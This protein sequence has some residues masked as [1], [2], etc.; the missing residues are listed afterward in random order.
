M[1]SMLRFRNTIGKFCKAHPG[2]Q[3]TQDRWIKT[4]IVHNMKSSST[5]ESGSAFDSS[6][7]ASLDSQATCVWD[8]SICLDPVFGPTLY[9]NVYKNSSILQLHEILDLIPTSKFHDPTSNPFELVISQA[10]HPF[11][12][13][14]YFFIHPCANFELI[15]PTL[16]YSSFILWISITQQVLG[17]TIITLKDFN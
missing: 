9:F 17:I 13:I 7:P 6:D 3:V 4:K 12:N 10:D 2:W 8:I 5:F 15:T 16:D 1:E 11:C 14:P